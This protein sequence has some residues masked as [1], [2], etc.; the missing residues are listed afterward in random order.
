[1]NSFVTK[2]LKPD[3]A[4]AVLCNFRWFGWYCKVTSIDDNRSLVRARRG[5]W[6]FFVLNKEDYA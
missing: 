3:V 4:M 6:S 1:M 2:S 5:S